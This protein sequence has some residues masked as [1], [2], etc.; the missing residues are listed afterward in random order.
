ML[1]LAILRFCFVYKEL[2]SKILT[3]NLET[4]NPQRLSKSLNLQFQEVTEF[5][6]LFMV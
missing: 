5:M 6:R 3:K 1:A 2:S 4:K